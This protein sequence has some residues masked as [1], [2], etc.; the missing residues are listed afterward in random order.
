MLLYVEMYLALKPEFE[1]AWIAGFAIIAIPVWVILV[2]VL[3]IIDEL[4]LNKKLAK[5]AASLERLLKK[6][7][8]QEKRKGKNI[9]GLQRQNLMIGEELDLSND[10]DHEEVARLEKIEKEEADRKEE[11]RLKA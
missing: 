5:Q 1:K 8:R 9:P 4:V 3:Y 10:T 6:F 7:D 2:N 11:E